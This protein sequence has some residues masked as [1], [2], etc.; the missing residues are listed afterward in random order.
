ML[1]FTL[2]PFPGLQV[3]AFLQMNILYMIF[4]GHMNFFIKKAFK[5]TEMFNEVV[6]IT[7]CYSFL[8]LVNIVAE[9]E[10]RKQVGAALLLTVVILIGT[11]ISLLIKKVVSFT[12]IT[13]K[14][15]KHPTVG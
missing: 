9:S 3:M 7:M 8:L 10:N 12:D 6:H 4:L 5:Y 13:G 15:G 2:A 14:G 11:N 1:T